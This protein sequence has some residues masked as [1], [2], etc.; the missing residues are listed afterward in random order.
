MSLW[1]DRQIQTFYLKIRDRSDCSCQ[2]PPRVCPSSLIKIR[3]RC[4]LSRLRSNNPVTLQLFFQTKISVL[5]PNVSGDTEIG[6][7]EMAPCHCC[8][9]QPP[10]LPRVTFVLTKVNNRK[11]GVVLCPVISRFRRWR[12]E[13]QE[14]KANLSCILSSRPACATRDPVSK[15]RTETGKP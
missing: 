7:R 3:E 10:G 9:P 4:G 15:T 2:L 5:S 1:V 8:A 6:G 11:S 14:F 13:G 12:Q